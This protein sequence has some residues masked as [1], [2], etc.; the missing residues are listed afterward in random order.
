MRELFARGLLSFLSLVMLF[1]ACRSGEVYSY[2]TKT[3]ISAIEYQLH[4]QFGIEGRYSSIHMR[5]EDSSALVLT[6]AG[7]PERNKDSL[8]VRRLKGGKWSQLS[9]VSLVSLDQLPIFFSLDAIASLQSIP[10]LIK[11]SI[12]R[13]SREVHTPGLRVKEILVHA[14]AHD[15]EGDSIRINMYIQPPGSIEKFEFSYDPD[16]SLKGVQHY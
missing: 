4:A 6:I 1:A 11:K 9:A 3:G 2:E 14:P 8:V 13:M 12:D 5:Y 10:D 7:M 15:P 16:G